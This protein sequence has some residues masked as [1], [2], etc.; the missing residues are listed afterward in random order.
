[1]NIELCLANKHDL[2]WSQQ[3]V[4]E[5]HYLHAPVDAR[6]NVLAYVVRADGER[7]GCLIFGRPEAT[8]CYDGQLTYGSQSDVAAG[9]ARFDRWEV[10]NLARVWMSEDLRGAGHGWLGS[11]AIS[12]AAKRVVADY[13]HQ[14]PPC[15]LNEPW[16]LRMLLSYCDTRH[17]TG[18]LYR[19]SGFSLARANTNGIQTWARP[20]RGLQGH[21][22]KAIERVAGQSQR[23]RIYRSQRA[24]QAVQET[25]L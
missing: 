18:A 20:L 7:A 11:W 13:L 12:E 5:H 15:F 19:A 23:S 3:Q 4:T 21:E 2:A 17:H 22:R 8:R 25:M 14:F 16:R 1:M 10:L 6:C 24:V 9:R